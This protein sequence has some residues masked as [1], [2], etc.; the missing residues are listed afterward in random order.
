MASIKKNYS[1]KSKRNIWR[2]I[3]SE[4]GYLVI[5][6]RDMNTKE[7]FFNCLKISDGKILFKNFQLE[8]KYW[9]GIEAVSKHII[10]FHKYRKPD[11]PGHKGIYALD[12]LS[13]SLIWHNEDLIFLLAK[14]DKVYA[15]QTT[16]EGRQ[17]FLLD[18]LTGKIIGELGGELDE[19]NKLREEFR[20]N[21]FCNDF[22]FPKIYDRD[23]E[24]SD[25]VNIISR[26]LADRKITGSINWLKIND[27]LM[28][29]YHKSNTDGTFNNYFEVFDIS[30]KR[31]ILKEILNSN[32]AKLAFESFFIINDLLFLLF[33]KTKLVVYKIM[34]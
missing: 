30:K 24:N 1:F 16:F 14:D 26:L 4:S 8:E 28:F 23:D 9:I 2:L 15:Y 5:E 32:S 3:P 22:L 21:D 11:M 34:Q 18:G 29:D 7:F 10:F 19:I 12:L 6:E 27:Q 31:V 17:Y 20:Q 33:E 13:Q 25:A